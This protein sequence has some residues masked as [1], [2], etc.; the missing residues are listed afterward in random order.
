[1]KKTFLILS[2]ICLTAFTSQAQLSL[3]IQA[4]ASTSLPDFSTIPKASGITFVQP[5]IVFD[6]KLAD[7]FS[8]RP[9]VNYLQSGFNSTT[10]LTSLVS[11]TDKFRTNNLLIPIDL[12]VPLKVGSGRLVLS[13]GPTVQIALNGSTDQTVT[14]GGVASTPI[15]S[16]FKIGSATGEL[17]QIN[18]GTNFGLGYRMNNGLE[19]RSTYNLALDNQ[20]NVGTSTATNKS[21]LISVL[22][23]YYLIRPKP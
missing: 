5:G 22:L 19:L 11:V 10:V 16:K 14:T 9:S 18:W 6:Y 4:G 23:A 21:H 1:M 7:F 3:G 8:L 12:C 2:S 20:I 13:A 15:N 17:K